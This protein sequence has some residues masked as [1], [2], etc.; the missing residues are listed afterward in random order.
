[1]SISEQIKELRE[2]AEMYEGLDGGKILS[3]AADTIEA[4]SAKLADMQRS[5]EDCGGGWIPCKDRLP[6]TRN[7]I[8]VCQSDGY[9]SVGYYSWDRAFLDLN[10]IPF[11]DVIAW[12]ELPE[13]YHEP[14]QIHHPRQRTP[15]AI[16]R[17]E[18]GK[19]I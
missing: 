13:P 12:R 9:V 5:A 18:R 4:L 10:S 6:E 2:V 7:N 3:E 19:S 8:L 1:M 17:S 11:D 16:P 15:Q 14:Q